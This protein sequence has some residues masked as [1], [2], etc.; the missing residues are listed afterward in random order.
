MAKFK[1]AILVLFLFIGTVQA[2]NGENPTTGESLI[3]L[4]GSWNF[5]ADY[6]NNGE[7]QAWFGSKFNDSGWDKMNVPGN[8]DIRDEYANY[9]GKGWYRTTFETPS[10]IDGKVVRLNF[11]AVGIDYKVWLNG[12]QI[13]NVTGG[14]FSNYIN[15]SGKL[16][17]G[18]KNTLV[19]CSDNT[20]RSGAYWSWGGIR[21]PVTLVLNKPVF[22]ESAHII[23]IP[24]LKKGTASVSVSAELFNASQTK[25]NMS[26]D[27]ELSFGGK[28]IKKGNVTVLLTG[29]SN[30]K[31]GFEFPLTKKEV[32]L[33]HFD[34][35]ISIR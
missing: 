34:F 8:W 17:S 13:A 23:A 27:Y 21:R 20:F 30:Q 2:A 25:E 22:L 1:I 35:Q 12:E 14:Y 28:L 31:A 11:E 15:I 6:Y 10:V 7:D 4:N 5:K 18:A 32:K 26:L 16:K 24:D 19:V 29:D 9:I 33:W 3:S